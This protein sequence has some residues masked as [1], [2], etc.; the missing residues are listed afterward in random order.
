MNMHWIDWFIVF[1]SAAFFIFLAYRSRKYAISTTDFLAANR[2]AGRYLLTL[3]EGMTGIGAVTVIGSWQMYYSA[4]LTPTWWTMVQL[5]ITIFILLTGWVIYRF[6]ETRALTMA[7]FLEMRYSQRF[8]IFAGTIAWISGIIN[9][10]IFPAISAN[11]FITYCGLPSH[12]SIPWLPYLS[13][14]PISTYHSLL[15]LVV[16]MA[17]YL[18]LAGG[19]VTV[20]ITDFFQSFFCNT[21]L[22]SILILLLIKF[23]LSDLF[24]GLVIAEKGKS[25]VDPFST[26]SSDFPYW[27]FLIGMIGMFYNRLAWQGSQAFN[28]SAKS[29]HEAKM[30]GVLS[31]FRDWAF[32][33]SLMLIPLFAYMIMHHPNYTSQAE[34]VNQLLSKIQND[35]VRN[36]M[37]T[38]MT[39]TLYMPVGLMGAFAAIMFAASICT[40]DTYLH[41]WGTILVQ[42]VIMPLRKKTLS[43]KRHILLLRMSFI[44]VA[45]FIVIFSSFFRQTTHVYM[46]FAITGAFWLGGA[47]AVIIGG[48]YTKWGTTAGAYAALISGSVLATSGLILDQSWKSWF[49]T[50]FFLSGQTTFFIAMLTAASLYV[51]VSL[52]GKRSS[53]NLDKMLHRGEYVVESDRVEVAPAELY[54]KWSIKKYCGFT[55]EFTFWD[56]FIYGIAIGKTLFFFLL[57]VF[58]SSLI[59]IVGLSQDGW[60]AFYK[61]VLIFNISVSFIFAVWLTIG[62]MRDMIRFRR[63]LKNAKR[64]LSDD[65]RV[66][67]VKNESVSSCSEHV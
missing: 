37:I 39:M 47:G 34:T 45:V 49:G 38:P 6:R 51:L 50:N 35:E 54:K 4:G 15:V 25:M 5:P 52:T 65:G 32:Q 21:V 18:V 17:L 36:Q 23:S 20:L 31:G 66:V 12:Y 28:S 62:G 3:A 41:S 19:Q 13:S 57:F 16:A 42:D 58:M 67:D 64:D 11:F 44:F 1:L 61:F 43:D 7:Q 10:G 8:R 14:C 27:Y 2:C 22:V 48:L 60:V 30:A 63:S 56:K 53:F 33:Y 9:F 59:A 24:D 26:G 46:F 40:N 29:P 55:N